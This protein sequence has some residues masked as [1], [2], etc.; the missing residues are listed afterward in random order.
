MQSP[1]MAKTGLGCSSLYAQHLSGPVQSQDR[2]TIQ[3][4]RGSGQP[5]PPYSSPGL[6]SLSV[7]RVGHSREL[8]YLSTPHPLALVLG[9]SL[10]ERAAWRGC[11]GGEPFTQRTKVPCWSR[12]KEGQLLSASQ[13]L[14]QMAAS[15]QRVSLFHRWLSYLSFAT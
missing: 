13:C 4:Q 6:T 8:S 2:N 3:Q 14:P 12:R 10:A 15:Y 1:R 7:L 5:I 9:F 11:L